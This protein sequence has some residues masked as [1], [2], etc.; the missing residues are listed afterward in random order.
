MCKEQRKV[1][2][3]TLKMKQIIVARK[4]GKE[5]IPF[6]VKSLVLQK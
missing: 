3:V 1:V 2:G 4:L 5:L 6:Q